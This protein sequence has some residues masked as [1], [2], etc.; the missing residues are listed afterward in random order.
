MRPIANVRADQ[1]SLCEAGA[2]LCIAGCVVFERELL[3]DIHAAR[4][5][6]SNY[7]MHTFST[8]NKNKKTMQIH[9]QL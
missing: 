7:K 3:S 5:V 8:T 6:D 4:A 1:M 2:I 9:S